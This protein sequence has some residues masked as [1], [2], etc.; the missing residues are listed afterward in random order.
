MEQ[1]EGYL[2]AL[3]QNRS[4]TQCGRTATVIERKCFCEPFVRFL[5][6]EARLKELLRRDRRNEQ[7]FRTRCRRLALGYA[8]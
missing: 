1:I 8:A 5:H 4:C 2:T 6:I 7:S 3:P